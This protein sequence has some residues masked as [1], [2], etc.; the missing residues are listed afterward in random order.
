MIRFYW[1]FSISLILLWTFFASCKKG[2]SKSDNPTS[3]ILLKSHNDSVIALTNKW[4]S[5]QDTV[6][7]INYANSYGAD[8][9]GVIYNPPGD[10]W[11][12][13]SNGT[14]VIVLEGANFSTTYQFLGGN[15]LLIPGLPAGLTRVCSITTLNSNTFIF[16][17]TDTSSN[18]GTY[19]RRVWL[20]K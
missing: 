4:T 2:A 15:Q 8:I 1:I 13:M 18:G 6:S 5:Y 7:N 10:Y 3:T 17:T 20:K 16:V 19:F 12:F 14:I 9:P 11:N